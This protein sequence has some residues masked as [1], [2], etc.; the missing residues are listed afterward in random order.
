VKAKC[1]INA[2]GPYTDSIR[3]MDDSSIKEICV[4]SSGVHI[5]LPGYYRYLVKV[6]TPTILNNI[7]TL[8]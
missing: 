8:P 5:V 1:V 4:P 6:I 3:K 2:T 7:A